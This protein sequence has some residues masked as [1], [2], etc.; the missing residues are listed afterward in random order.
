MTQGYSGYRGGFPTN[1]VQYR[2]DADRFQFPVG[3]YEPG[4]S[5]VPPTYLGWDRSRGDADSGVHVG[6]TAPS[7]LLKNTLVSFSGEE[8][9]AYGPW[10][11]KMQAYIGRISHVTPLNVCRS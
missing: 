2:V 7:K 8:P 4:I 11:S 5:Q 10:F 6:W 9:H 3:N 1:Y